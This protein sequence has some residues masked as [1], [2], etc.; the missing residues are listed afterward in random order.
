MENNVK[1]WYS[2]YRGCLVKNW[3]DPQTG[4]IKQMKIPY[5]Q[6]D[7]FLNYLNYYFTYKLN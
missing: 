2:K 4:L 7:N 5:N 6:P 3:I 1:V